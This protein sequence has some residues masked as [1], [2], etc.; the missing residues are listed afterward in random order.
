MTNPVVASSS[1]NANLSGKRALVTGASRGIGRRVAVT[2]A[3][4]G[5]SVVVTSRQSQSLDSLVTELTE[6]GCRAVPVA[7]DVVDPQQVRSLASILEQRLGGRDI[8]VNNAGQAAS[9]KFL[10]HSDRLWDRMLAVNLTGVFR[11]TRELVPF[12]VERNWGRIINI[13]SIASK[14]GGKYIAAYTASKHGVLGLTRSL[15]VELVGHQITVNAICPGYV[16]T[17]MTDATVENITTRTGMKAAQAR[18]VLAQSSLQQ[19]LIDPQEIADL[20]VWLAGEQSRG[21]TGQAINIDG[22]AVMF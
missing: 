22:G 6:R 5:A 7:C 10:G 16:D 20:C 9:E 21:I 3:E 14:V 19:R 15:A 2:L 17:P 4:A 11:V 8:L 13:A 1:S 12:M 18:H